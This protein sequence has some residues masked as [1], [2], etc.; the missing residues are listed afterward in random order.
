M[1]ENTCDR[2]I[3]DKNE[4][5]KQNCFYA[6]VVVLKLWSQKILYPMCLDTDNFLG[7]LASPTN[8]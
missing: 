5:F 1:N 8:I 2:Q 7:L 4:K 6:I 3:D